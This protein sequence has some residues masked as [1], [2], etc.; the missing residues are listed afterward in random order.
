MQQVPPI[1]YNSNVR[2]VPLATKWF[3]KYL[4]VTSNKNIY[5]FQVRTGAYFK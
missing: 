1:F 3:I 4:M 2:R 5:L